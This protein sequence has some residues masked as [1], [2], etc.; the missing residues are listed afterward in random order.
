VLSDRVGAAHDLLRNGV[1]G[2][3]VPAGDVDESARALLLLASDRDLR[4]A[5]GARS[6]ELARDWGYGPSV[7]GFLAAVREAVAHHDD[8]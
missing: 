5:Y 8:S 1:N 2:I 7:A 6:R 4:L 3:L